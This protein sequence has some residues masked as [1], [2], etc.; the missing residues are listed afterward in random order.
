MTA[1]ATLDPFTAR[2]YIRRHYL[3]TQQSEIEFR[4]PSPAHPPPPQAPSAGST[5]PLQDPIL[6]LLLEQVEQHPLLLIHSQIESAS[7]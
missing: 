6:S 3:N 2:H 4:A 1:A 5:G 7:I